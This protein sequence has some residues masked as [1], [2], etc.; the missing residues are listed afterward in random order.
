MITADPKSGLPV[1]QGIFI[2]D[3]TKQQ[4]ETDLASPIK[5]DFKRLFKNEAPKNECNPK[6]V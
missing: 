1:H 3:D 4:I 2:D 6:T 5:F